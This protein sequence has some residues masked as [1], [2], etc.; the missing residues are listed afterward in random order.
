[1]H[2]LFVSLARGK[3]HNQGLAT[4]LGS[5]MEL[6]RETTPASAERFH[7]GVCVPCSGRV[8]VRPDD[9]AIHEVQAPVQT[10]LGVCLAL[11]LGEDHFPN[12]SPSPPI[13]A[14][15]DGLP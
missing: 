5:Q 14:T 15:G 8:L 12:P 10:T 7:R 9:R 2:W 6:G 1:M 13:E 4:T 11:Q 3:H